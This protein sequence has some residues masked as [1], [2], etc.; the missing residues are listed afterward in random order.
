M[1]GFARTVEDVAWLCAALAG[2][3]RAAWWHAGDEGAVA[4]AS[5]QP[6]LDRLRL[7]VVRSAEWPHAEP[8]MQ[9]RFDADVAALAAAGATVEVAALPDQLDEVAVSVHRTIMQREAADSLGALVA[10]QPQSVSATLRTYLEGG[11]R[12]ARGDYEAAL[13]HREQLITAF[14][15]WAQ[16]YDVILTPPA[17][18]EAPGLETTGDP[19][20]CTRWTL[21]GAPALTL[22]T[23]LGPAG[24]PLGLQLVGAPGEDRKLLH[25]A[26]TLMQAIGVSFFP[27]IAGGEA[28]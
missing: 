4:P 25:A 8:A 3:P 15:P 28:T 19:R 7:A 18:G 22:P 16:G 11:A 1:G 23:G 21:V 5:G 12:I 6:R 14:T 24:L 26:A 2:E 20:F 13:R 27:V 9:A 17:V 10:Q